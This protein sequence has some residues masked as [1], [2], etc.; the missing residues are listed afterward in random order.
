MNPRDDAQGA[1]FAFVYRSRR[2][3]TFPELFALPAAVTLAT[4]AKAFNTHVNTAYQHIRRG[5]FPCTV[6]RPGGRY[7]VPT[8]AL[9]EALQIDEVPIYLEDVDRGA[10]N[11]ARFD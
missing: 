2:S 3:M 4:A 1:S 11:S 9:L 10:E 6:I 5:T 7:L 8:K